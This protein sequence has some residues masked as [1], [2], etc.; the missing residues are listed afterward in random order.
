MA[1]IDRLTTGKLSAAN[2]DIE[3]TKRNSINLKKCPVKNM[4]YDTKNYLK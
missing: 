2:S 4:V 1:A 3:K